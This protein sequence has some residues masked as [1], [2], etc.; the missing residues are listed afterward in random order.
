MTEG[1][2]HLVTVAPGIDMEEAKLM[3]HKHQIEKLLVVSDHYEL[4]RT[5]NHQRY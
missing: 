1:R 4:A 5:D 3:L 2:K